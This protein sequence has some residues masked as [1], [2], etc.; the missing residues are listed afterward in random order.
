METVNWVKRKPTEEQKIFGSYT[1]DR[2]LLSRTYKEFLQT[3]YTHTH[4]II[5]KGYGTEQEVLKKERK[6]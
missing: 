3:K 4:K 1:S 2:D 5:S 6:K